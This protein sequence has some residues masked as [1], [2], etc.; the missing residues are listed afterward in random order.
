MMT[1]S[2]RSQNR[3]GPGPQQTNVVTVECDRKITYAEY[4]LPEGEPVVF[5]HGTP[6]SRR[7]GELLAPAARENGIRLLSPNRPG[8]GGSSA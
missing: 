4:G 6:G 2:N 7:L 5:L 1:A 8:Y 3:Q